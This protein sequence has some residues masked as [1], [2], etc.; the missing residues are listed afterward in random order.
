MMAHPVL[1]AGA[2]S[3]EELARSAVEFAGAA[4]ALLL[5]RFETGVSVE[6]KNKE[7]TDPVSEADRSSQDHLEQA[8][9]ARYPEHDV[10]GE[11]EPKEKEGV[12]NNKAST[13]ADFLWVL[14][15]L[16]GTKNFLH[17][18]PVWACSVGVLF[19]GRP[20]AGAIFTPETAPKGDGTIYKAWAGGG[21]YRNG[22]PIQVPEEAKPTG[23][24]IVSLPATYWTQFRP[25]GPLR[26]AMGEIRAPGSIGYELAHVARGGLHYALF[27]APSIWDVAA[28][29]VLVTEAGG[30]VLARTH[31]ADRWDTLES[32]FPDTNR[33]EDLE[34]LRKW[35]RSVLAGNTELSTYVARHLRKVNRPRLWRRSRRFR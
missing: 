4:G 24:R 14:D 5:E 23:R 32:F 7:K 11:E 13:P 3:A 27:G 25:T 20:V 33:L 30:T 10:L 6:Y 26:N 8:I 34:A 17:G 29:A 21:A 9:R 16:D 1:P 2:P 31:G 19:R 28:G 15:P 35:R 12:L 22:Q 18:L